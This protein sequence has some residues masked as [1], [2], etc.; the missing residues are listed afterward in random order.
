MD[1]ILSIT[2]AFLITFSAVPIVIRVFRSMDL[3]DTPDKRKIHSVS[4]PSL[5][6][7]AIFLG[8]MIALFFWVPLSEL[9][10]YKYLLLAIFFAFLLGVR[11]DIASLHALDKLTIQIFAALLVVF[12][13]DIRFTELYG[14]FGLSQ[15]PIGVAEFLS[16][17]TIVVLTNAF[18]LIDGIDG[19]AG[20]VAFLVLGFFGWWFLETGQTTLGFISISMG[21]AVLGFLFFNWAPSRIFMGD[22]GSLVLGFILSVLMIR[23]IEVNNSISMSN[24]IK[25]SAPVALSVA[26]LVLPV[27]DTLR[28]FI[29]RWMAGRSPMSADK[30]HTHHTLIKL[31]LGHAS[32]TLVLISFNISAIL[33]AW[34]LQPLGNNWASLIILVFAISFGGF[35]DY[36]LKQKISSLSRHRKNQR[37]GLNVG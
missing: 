35:L 26:L 11:D 2:T 27:Y 17:F 25:F 9:S 12:L 33:L 6:G 3:L 14:V 21:A 30:N 13:A 34:V 15:L 29:I 32:S 5:G 37:V 36:R 8:F 23:F 7:I 31:G 18:N 22:T 24:P 19:L 16:I 20:S 10:E 28:V 1:V 4:T